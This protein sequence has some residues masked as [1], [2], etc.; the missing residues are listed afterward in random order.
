MHRHPRTIAAGTSVSR[1]LNDEWRRLAAVRGGC[2]IASWP[3]GSLATAG[4]D[5]AAR[6]GARR[7]PSD[8]RGRSRSRRAG[9]VA[10]HDPL[11][12]RIGVVQRR[13][14]RASS[15]RPCAGTADGRPTTELFDDLVA[16]AWLVIRGFPI[17]RRPAKIAVNVL[18]DA[19]YVT[20]VRPRR[21]RSA[22]EVPND[23]AADERR[24][25]PSGLDGR[26]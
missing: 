9:R 3:A 10:R 1:R 26:P 13:R 6:H 7:W 4:R 21:L 17:E 25:G 24:V 12:A 8:G 23:L 20:C 15:T 22:S 2:R 16:N 5:R 11:A 14:A 18:R 19:E